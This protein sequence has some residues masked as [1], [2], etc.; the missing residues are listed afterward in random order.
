MGEK[1][2]L[3]LPGRPGFLKERQDLTQIHYPFLKPDNAHKDGHPVST[4]AM[5][6]ARLTPRTDLLP[7]AMTDAK[8]VKSNAFPK[9]RPQ[10]RTQS[11]QRTQNTRFLER[12]PGFGR[13][14]VCGLRF[15]AAAAG[16]QM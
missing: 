11:T 15:V 16:L 9:A 4:C 6:P 3:S 5:A 7:G 14:P 2:K 12:P 13:C 8:D 10:S 1:A